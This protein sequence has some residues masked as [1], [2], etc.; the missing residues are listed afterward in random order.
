MA[1]EKVAQYK[2]T[3]FVFYFFDEK[4]EVKVL[5][6]IDRPLTSA[7]FDMIEKNLGAYRDAVET[8]RP[9]AR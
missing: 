3:D 8:A 1:I 9:H 7:E 4:G 2:A 6:T 5:T